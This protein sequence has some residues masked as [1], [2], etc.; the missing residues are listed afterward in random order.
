VVPAIPVGNERVSEPIMIS[1]ESNI[2]VSEPI[3]IVSVPLPSTNVLP[4]T[5]ISVTELVIGAV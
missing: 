1:V 5:S 2:T 3:V 4:P